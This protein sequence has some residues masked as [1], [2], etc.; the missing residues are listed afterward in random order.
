MLEIKTNNIN[1]EMYC[2]PGEIWTAF[3]QMLFPLYTNSLL[4]LIDPGII[5]TTILTLNSVCL[6]FHTLTWLI[7]LLAR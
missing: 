2:Q 4:P 7:F 5:N 3:A 6:I 1:H